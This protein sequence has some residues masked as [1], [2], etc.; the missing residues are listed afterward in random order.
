[1]HTRIVT[2]LIVVLPLDSWFFFAQILSLGISCFSIEA[3]YRALATTATELAWLRIVF[4]ELR[5]F[6]Y[7]VP[8]LWCDNVSA[9][10]LFANPVFH[11]RSKHIEVDY[12]YV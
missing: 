1:M 6:L 11:S 8:V 9:I 4:K 7:H 10:A 5:L 3:E 12:H 2:L